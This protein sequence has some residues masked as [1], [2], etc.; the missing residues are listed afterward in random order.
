MS[1]IN[2]TCIFYIEDKNDQSKYKHFCI[3]EGK[4]ILSCNPD[5]RYFIDKVHAIVKLAFELKSREKEQ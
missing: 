1:R 3:M 2:G 5:C 4:Y